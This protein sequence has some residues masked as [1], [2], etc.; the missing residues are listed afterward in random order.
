M[1]E[2]ADRFSEPSSLG[3]RGNPTVA[4]NVL[5]NAMGGLLG[6]EGDLETKGCARSGDVGIPEFGNPTITV[7]Q[8]GNLVKIICFSYKEGKCGLSGKPCGQEDGDPN[9]E[10]STR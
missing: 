2:N 4:L 8:V 5:Q 10:V 3:G 6:R 1:V 9:V 7:E